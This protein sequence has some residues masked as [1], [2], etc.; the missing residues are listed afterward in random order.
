MD[1]AVGRR[2]LGACSAGCT[3]YLPQS[4][5]VRQQSQGVRLLVHYGNR[6]RLRIGAG[7]R[8][9]PRKCRAKKSGTCRFRGKSTKGGGFGGLCETLL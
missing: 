3:G 6:A 2:H 9:G 7:Q 4:S 5:T 8:R 1:K